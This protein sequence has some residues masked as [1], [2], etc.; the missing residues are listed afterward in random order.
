MLLAV[1]FSSSFPSLL[2]D[3]ALLLCIIMSGLSNF[4]SPMSDSTSD[5]KAI[6]WPS[7]FLDNCVKTAD[8]LAKADPVLLIRNSDSPNAHVSPDDPI[9]E[10]ISGRYEIDAA[11]YEWVQDALAADISQPPYH[12]ALYLCLPER[13]EDPLEARGFF[14]AVAQSLAR[15]IK[16]DLVTLDIDDMANLSEHY[17]HA[18]KVDT[19]GLQEN[20]GIWPNDID[21]IAT[22]SKHYAHALKINTKSFQGN[23][24]TW[25]KVLME[26]HNSVPSNEFVNS[27]NTSFWIPLKRLATAPQSKYFDEKLPPRQVVLHIPGAYRFTDE[28]IGR[29]FLRYLAL[30][31]KDE[32][33]KAH[34]T[35]ILTDS[36]NSK[37]SQASDME[38]K[39]ILDITRFN[40]SDDVFEI[41]P[42]QSSSLHETLD[43]DARKER[44]RRQI[45]QLQKLARRL[46]TSILNVDDVEEWA[47]LQPYST[48]AL[49]I[50]S[51]LATVDGLITNGTPSPYLV[52]CLAEVKD[53]SDPKEI[54]N[55]IQ[56]AIKIQESMTR[57]LETENLAGQ[58]HKTRL[59]ADKGK[60]ILTAKARKELIAKANSFEKKIFDLIVDTGKSRPLGTRQT[61]PILRADNQSWSRELGRNVVRYRN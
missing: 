21:D 1:T 57:E 5:T 12:R 52:R 22:L 36:E 3:I 4:P 29:N 32:L 19:E 24:G 51:Q 26:D 40:N 16:A 20:N 37:C 45:N 25:P 34:V 59:E 35:I 43:A 7:W 46:I 48:I 8:D 38:P 14:S 30:S 15:D 53:W 39:A 41:L 27:P 23:N 28:K 10:S 49:D 61:P 6:N 18:L 54:Y 44:S 42:I 33:A 56:E 13:H 58:S 31:I 11:F 50:S 2:P 17:A 47:V 60:P 9:T 55:G